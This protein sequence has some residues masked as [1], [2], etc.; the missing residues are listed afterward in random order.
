MK[1][2]SASV[3]SVKIWSNR[4]TIFVHIVVWFNGAEAGELEPVFAEELAEVC[5]WVSVFTCLWPG[6]TIIFVEEVNHVDIP[7]SPFGSI[8]FQ[9][10]EE[11]ASLPNG[12]DEGT[13][14][15]WDA[16][17]P[18][19]LVDHIIFFRHSHGIMDC[20]ILFVSFLNKLWHVESISSKFLVDWLCEHHAGVVWVHWLE[21]SETNWYE[22][23]WQNA[24]QVVFR[25]IDPRI[26]EVV[27]PIRGSLLLVEPFDCS[28]LVEFLSHFF[29]ERHVSNVEI[30]CFGIFH[31]LTE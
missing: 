18:S 31:P 11:A 8:D 20:H 3:G 6:L 30:T 22:V 12:R 2:V 24:W 28:S 25:S 21:H 5:I 16:I 9:T 29:A 4:W 7:R 19:T 14:H 26:N 15:P 17:M 13:T 23:F 10:I 1:E 27:I